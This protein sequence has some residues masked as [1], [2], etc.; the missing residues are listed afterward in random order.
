MVRGAA[1]REAAVMLEPDDR[2]HLA[3]AAAV[4]AVLF[5]IPHLYWA[6]G[7]HAGL[8]GQTM[9]GLLLAI[10]FAAIVLGVVAVGVGVA[11]AQPV[12]P[13]LA[14]V[15]GWGAAGLLGVRGIAG[16]VPGLLTLLTGHG[17][18]PAFVAVFEVLFCTGGV[19]FAL[20]TLEAQRAMGD[21][22]AAPVARVAVP[23][24]QPARPGVPT[25]RAA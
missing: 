20:A 5:A 16:V 10:D 25:A 19:L 9:G 11:L 4:W 21:A 23:S 3:Y 22:P 18:W 1:P 6:A 13:R 24:A 14:I 17:D 12:V 8:G 15:G 2:R 7:G